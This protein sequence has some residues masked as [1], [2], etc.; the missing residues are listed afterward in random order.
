MKKIYLL[1]PVLTMLF[2]CSGNA[3]PDDGS[4]KPG[5]PLGDDKYYA[6]FMYNYPR[7]TDES[8]SGME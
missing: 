1:L 5:H 4:Y 6:L 3:K 2:S 8:A 7:V